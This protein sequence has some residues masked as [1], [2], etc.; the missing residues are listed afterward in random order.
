[1]DTH[2][3]RYREA[4]ARLWGSL[5]VEPVERRIRL[6]RTGCTVRVQELG[7]GP[8]VLFLHGGS[9]CGTSW[10]DL[11]VRM[12]GFRCV[13]LDRPG[14]GLSDPLR[15]PVTALET[16]AGLADV[17]VADTLDAL[18]LDAAHLVASS[19]G[20]YFAFRAALAHPARV[21]RIVELG[22][23]AGAPAPRLPAV[24]RL[25]TAPV[26]GDL[27]AR[28]PASPSTV[29]GIF[30]GIGHGASLDAGRIG[31][32]AIE[33]YAALLRHTQTQRNDL[34]LGRL[35]LSPVHGL[36]PLILL[37]SEERAAIRSPVL[38]IWGDADPFGD[39]EVARGFAA[40]F[41]D[42]DLV[43]VPGGHAPWMDDPGGVASL[44]VGFLAGAVPAST[45]PVPGG[46]L[47]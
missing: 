47:P 23:S 6:E 4:E 17:L 5:G 15:S 45:D 33:A 32:E 36:S 3:V 26:L 14:T 35:F 30:R 21:T 22:W 8:A 28:M 46:P 7:E 38:F 27:L 13:L 34:R 41:T 39:V 20:G 12:P 11:A 42:A 18:G 16:L 29:R 24:M 10:A 40:A 44:V 19:F 9:T 43:I 25:G 31:P 1:M 37:S 2:E